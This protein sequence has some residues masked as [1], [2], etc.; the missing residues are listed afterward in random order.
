MILHCLPLLSIALV[1]PKDGATVPTQREV[2]KAYFEGARA[3]R[4]VRMDNAGDRA[5]LF[6]AGSH[7]EPLM[8]EWTGETNRVYTIEV[9]R[10]G[11][12]TET[13]S[14]TNRTTAY[15]TNLELGARYVWKVSTEGEEAAQ[16]SFA[17]ESLAPR[18][19]RAAGV[20]N[21]RDLGG[22]RTS[23]GRRVRENLLFR[24]AGLR[25]SSQTSGGFLRRKVIL[26]ARRI[27]PEGIETLRRDFAIKTDVELRTPQETAGM[28]GSVLGAD[29]KWVNVSFAAYGFIGNMVRGREP[30][31]KLFKVFADKANYPILLHCSGGRD[32]TGT[33]A[34][35]LNGLLG[36]EE[37]D[38]C[39]DW[40]ASIFADQGMGFSSAR[41]EDL[42]TYLHALPG[43]T[44][45]D[46]IEGY[47]RSC[48]VTDEEIARFR[49]IMVE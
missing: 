28:V 13:F 30:F 1:A 2:Q 14:V 37:D 15:L 5:R 39:R 17:T 22:W 32:R 12:A 43:E 7:Q 29:V 48:G 23:D 11:G 36:V 26:G 40:E 38:L 19:L 31:A 44:L 8:L 46:K 24:S 9:A 45:K 18:F 35:L 3:E 41:L 20:G 16:A 6:A 42:L 47:A 25:F 10:A 34:F 21:F 49:E 4:V 33:L 27:T